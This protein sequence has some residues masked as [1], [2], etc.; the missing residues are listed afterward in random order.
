MGRALSRYSS[1]QSR[2][3]P[4]SNASTPHT[5]SPRLVDV[6]S[7]LD[8]WQAPGA[9][10]GSA[11]HVPQPV[12]AQVMSSRGRRDCRGP[13]ASETMEATAADR[14]QIRLQQ[15]A[16]GNAP[17]RVVAVS[18]RASF[19]AWSFAAVAFNNMYS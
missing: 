3:S 9:F 15:A 8:V 18:S 11:D 10:V 17:T 12:A 14:V 19:I 4:L 5:D 1:L 13:L 16:R 6:A 2:Q 7:V